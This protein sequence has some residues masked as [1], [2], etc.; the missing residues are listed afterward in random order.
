[1]DAT[2]G[3][4]DSWLDE[5]L[6]ADVGRFKAELIDM[7]ELLQLLVETA[8]GD[9]GLRGSSEPQLSH[10]A[11]LAKSFE[12]CFNGNLRLCIKGE[13]ARDFC[14][15]AAAFDE[16][17]GVRSPLSQ[18]DIRFHTWLASFLIRVHT[19]LFIDK[20]PPR[21]RQQGK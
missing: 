21:R 17:S 2:K 7:R 12:A 16:D 19:T 20:R 13:S 6:D 11:A 5:S 1:M 15:Q 18:R 8:F 4:F 10:S 9:A 3:L 14:I